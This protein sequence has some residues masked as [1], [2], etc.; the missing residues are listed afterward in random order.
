MIFSASY[1]KAFAR[2]DVRMGNKEEADSPSYS[3][4]EFN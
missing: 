2:K 4:L 3:T 1:F